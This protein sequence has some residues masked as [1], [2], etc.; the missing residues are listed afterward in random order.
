MN[1]DVNSRTGPQVVVSKL[2]DDRVSVLDGVLIEETYVTCLLHRSQVHRSHHRILEKAGP[3]VSGDLEIEP[4]GH[5]GV[6]DFDPFMF[7]AVGGSHNMKVRR[8]ID[9][10]SR[11]GRRIARAGD[12]TRENQ[13]NGWVHQE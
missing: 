1:L 6:S 5:L 8:S 7:N 10:A 9:G 4:E 11:G 13:S 2:G 3:K 12:R